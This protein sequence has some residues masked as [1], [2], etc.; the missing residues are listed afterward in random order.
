MW[1]GTR[2]ALL[3]VTIVAYA[4]GAVRREPSVPRIF[5]GQ[6]A[7]AAPLLPLLRANP[8]LANWVH[9][10][11]SWYLLIALHGYDYATPLA[12]GFFPLYP[13]TIH[14]VT[15]LV[16]SQATLMVALTLT[17]LATLIGYFG[18]GLL[19][20]HETHMW[21]ISA[22]PDELAGDV[23]EK[24]TGAAGWFIAITAAYPF[25][26]FL[27]APYTESFFL[28]LTVWTFFC[29]RR[30]HWRWAIALALLAGMARPTAVVLLP[31]LVWEYG[32]QHG[33]WRR[34]FWRA[35]AWRRLA[36]LRAL[37]G[38]LAVAAAEPAGLGVYLLFM[39]VRYGSA[40]GP[41]IA[42][43][44]YHGRINWP[45]WRTIRVIIARMVATPPLNS[46]TALLYLDGTI[47]LGFL[48][49]TL[50]NIHRLPI[51]YT[52]Y[53]VATFCLLLSAPT[54]YRAEV[55][56]SLGRYLLLAFP[57][58]LLAARWAQSRPW[59]GWAL[60]GAGFT[61]QTFFVLLFL[62]GAWIE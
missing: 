34:A 13:L 51:L 53:L 55:V 44:K 1:L 25:A 17:N 59:L 20:A 10:D 36:G 22:A 42:Q 3:L 38:W 60:I 18:L 30:G 9:W 48:L 21:R 7:L 46:H 37:A 6:P 47:L 40:R 61:L 33:F 39:K 16:G 8:T 12:V 45:F 24:A 4:F 54:P 14:L 26:F 57:I 52:L 32:R 23:Q 49:I 50:L 31:A 62:N 11:A 56:P 15:L 27:F 28:A 35:G 5:S 43:Y 29:A 2:L 19:A 58:F 41:L